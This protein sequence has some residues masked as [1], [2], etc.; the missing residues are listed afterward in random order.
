[1]R[2]RLELLEASLSNNDMFDAETVEA[3]DN[4]DDLQTRIADLQSEMLELEATTS[5]REAVAERVNELIEEVAGE[6]SQRR[7]DS[8]G[9]EMAIG[10]NGSA[11]LAATRVERESV[12]RVRDRPP[13]NRARGLPDDTVTHGD[14]WSPFGR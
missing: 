7:L 14:H 3:Q 1:M 11:K 4:R 13:I 2:D 6:S 9:S 10:I 5:N 12:V 8:N